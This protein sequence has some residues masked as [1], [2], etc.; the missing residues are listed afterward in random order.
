MAWADAGMRKLICDLL[1]QAQQSKEIPKFPVEPLAD[2]LQ[3]AVDG[4]TEQA[5]VAPNE[6][7]L[8]VSGRMLQQMLAAVLDGRVELTRR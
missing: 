8:V 3:A 1:S 7:D 5:S 6:V 4:L 2:L